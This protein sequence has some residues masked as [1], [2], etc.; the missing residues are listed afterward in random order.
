VCAAASPGGGGQRREAFSS[1][2]EQVG[3]PIAKIK[4][5]DD[6]ANERQILMWD[7]EIRHAHAVSASL[8]PPAN[9]D[10]P[11]IPIKGSVTHV[12]LLRKRIK[13]FY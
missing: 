10:Q 3:D 13:T 5:P 9:P 2:Q 8:A 12:Y 7:L 11:P 4:T 6:L 1:V